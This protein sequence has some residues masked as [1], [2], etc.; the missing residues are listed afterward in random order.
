MPLTVGG[1][2]RTLSDIRDLLNAGAG[3][4]ILTSMDRDGTKDGYDIKLTKAVC[5]LIN[6]PLVAS[7]GAG[8]LKDFYGVFTQANADAALAASV[9]HYK[10]YSIK[11]TKH[12]LKKREINVRIRVVDPRR[13]FPFARRMWCFWNLQPC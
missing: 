1:G 4:I 13:S 11:E 2:V 3:E 10:E 9:F 6:I 8:T 5:E 7:G 12:Y